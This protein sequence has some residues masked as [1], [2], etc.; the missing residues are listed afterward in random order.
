[1]RNIQS[2]I[3][4]GTNNVQLLIADIT[5][6]GLTIL[7]RDSRISALAENMKYNLL[8]GEGI[9]R[10]FGIIE[11]FVTISRQYNCEIHLIA[12]SAAR[13]A[14]NIEVL[15]N[16]LRDKFALKLQIISGEE[17][18]R[19]NGLAN[20]N[21]FKATSL[22]LFDIGGGSTEFTFIRSNEIIRTES[23]K[24]G[25][26]RLHNQFGD[27]TWQETEHIKNK[28]QVLKIKIDNDTVLAGIGGTVTSLGA[29]LQDMKVYDETLV[30]GFKIWNADIDGIYNKILTMSDEQ[31]PLLIPFNPLTRPL[32]LT[33]IIIVREIIA[34]FKG[35]CFFVSDRTWQLGVLEEIRS[36]RWN[37]V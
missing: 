24:L 28:L 25:I 20:I 7:K 14:K 26:R 29:M 1:M 6:D 15:R 16:L 13:E 12:T 8:S 3:D 11:E 30:Q 27:N 19:L 23:I 36:G 2:I 33:G 17:E 4:I 22:L 18:A 37:N 31:V 9:L 5:L 10:T 21:E 32:L 34:H 35:C